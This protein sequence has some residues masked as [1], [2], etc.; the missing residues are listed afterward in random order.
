MK[1][2]G[3]FLLKGVISIG[4]IGALLYW[5]VDTAELATAFQAV[6]Y[7][8]FAFSTLLFLFQQV[9]IAYCWQIILVAQGN[10]IPFLRIV[11]VH[12]IG[13]FF[14]TF[15][16][17]SIGM[18]LVRA[19]TLKKHLKK[20]VDAMSSMFVTRVVGFLVNFAIAL[21]VA[22]PVARQTGNSRL[23]WVV[24]AMTLA[25]CFAV[26]LL[27]HPRLLRLFAPAFQK[28]K[29]GKI[30]AKIEGFQEGTIALRH[31][32]GAMV[33][34]FALSLFFQIVGIYIIYLVG[35]SLNLQVAAYHYFIFIPL[36]TT[37]TI[38][39]LSIAGIGVR[40]GAFVYFFGGLGVSE[41]VAFSLS[42]LV[43][44]QWVGMALTGGVVYWTSGI[45]ISRRKNGQAVAE[46]N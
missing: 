12:W 21:V 36:I 24:L 13:S 11:Q 4:L 29:L 40:E 37:I 39:P 41:P 23:F 25:F 31:H 34:L 46:M 33:K 16:P 35:L 1:Q 22:I 32:K 10:D 42:L 14:G 26:W 2:L 7:Y 44:A 15:M 19:Y 5:K 28:F 27:L 18:D 43:F 17:T 8:L 3:S 45:N 30:Y 9:V 6:D 20:G 38:V